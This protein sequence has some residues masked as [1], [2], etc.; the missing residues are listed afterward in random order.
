MLSIT[1]RYFQGDMWCTEPFYH[2]LGIVGH[3]DYARK[4]CPMR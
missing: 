4:D 3:H 2:L 1:D